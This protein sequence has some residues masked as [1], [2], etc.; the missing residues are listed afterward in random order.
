[1]V[2]GTLAILSLHVL[3]SINSHDSFPNII[4]DKLI[5]SSTQ[6]HRVL[7][8][9]YSRIPLL[10]VAFFPSQKKTDATFDHG[11]F[12]AYDWINQGWVYNEENI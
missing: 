11:T 6:F 4:G 9:N 2:I 12:R 8:T 1:M 7:Y 3:G 10:K 5:N